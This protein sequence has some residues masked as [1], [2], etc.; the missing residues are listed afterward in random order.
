MKKKM[1]KMQL[2]FHKAQGMND[3][4]Y[5]MDGLGSKAPIPLPP[6]F[7]ISYAE[8]FDSTRD[9]KQ[10]FRRY[11]SIANVLPH[12]ICCKSVVKILLM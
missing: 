2:A 11:I 3:C 9:L 1:E 8:K 10:H 4:L 7:K 6:K 5:N 12:M